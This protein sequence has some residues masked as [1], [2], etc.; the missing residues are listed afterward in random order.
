M[1]CIQSLHNSALRVNIYRNCIPIIFPKHKSRQIQFVPS[2]YSS[3][4]EDN[5]VE[6]EFN[7]GIHILV[8][9]D[10]YRST[11]PRADKLHLGPTPVQSFVDIA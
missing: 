10:P 8:E 9:E 4:E 3:D 5:D 7:S 11:K 1:Q 6:T 2:K